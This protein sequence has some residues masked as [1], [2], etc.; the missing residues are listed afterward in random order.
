MFKQ[1]LI[2]SAKRN[3]TCHAAVCHSTHQPA[4]SA[5]QTHPLL[6]LQRAIGNQRTLRMMQSSSL[7]AGLTVSRIGNVLAQREHANQ[8]DLRMKP[9][10]SVMS[11]T[12][13]VSIS[14][15][16]TECEVEDKRKTLAA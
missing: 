1:K 15:A 6:H 3:A 5:V 2:Q 8:T 10:D 12:H 13:G 7:P 16:C 4:V 11:A 9:R 14:R